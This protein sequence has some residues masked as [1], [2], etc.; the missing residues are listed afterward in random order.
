M[1]NLMH[2]RTATS[3]GPWSSNTCRLDTDPGKHLEIISNGHIKVP[4]GQ[5]AKGCAGTTHG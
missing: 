5:K 2:L 1:N 4:G 3:A